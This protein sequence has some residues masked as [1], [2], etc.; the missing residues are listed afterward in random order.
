MQQRRVKTVDAKIFQTVK[1]YWK[2]TA[3]DDR[4]TRQQ[5]FTFSPSWSNHDL[6]AGYSGCPLSLVPP[7]Q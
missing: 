5:I 7:P 4:D 1:K 6:L 3:G 2:F